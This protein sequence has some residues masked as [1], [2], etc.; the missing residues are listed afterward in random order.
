[1][2]A[3]SSCGAAFG[4]QQVDVLA[5]AETLAALGDEQD[6]AA[7]R[8]RLRGDGH[9]LHRLIE[10][11]VGGISHVRR[12]DDVEEVRDRPQRLPRRLRDRRIVRGDEL[13]GE[14]ARDPLAL[15]ERDVDAERDVALQ[16]GVAHLF[17]DRVA[18][19]RAPRRLRM[20]DHACVVVGHDRAGAPAMAGS[21]ALPPPE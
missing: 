9:A 2:R 21:T 3:S 18:F 4:A 20:P 16:R 1:M 10:H 5:G 11:E 17:E 7:G 19:R 14:D 8:A 6:R 12:D 15:V 13:A